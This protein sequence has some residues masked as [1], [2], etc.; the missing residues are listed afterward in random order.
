MPETT[1]S[2]FA[3]EMSDKTKATALETTKV[4]EQTYSSATK[5]AADFNRQWIEMVR[6]NTNST[7]D[8]VHQLFGVKSPT[9]FFE[10]WSAHAR[11]QFEAFTEQSKHLTTLAQKVT[12][13]TVEPLQAGMKGAA[14]K[15]A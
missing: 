12:T 15:A 7:L 5:G 14:A 4:L 10:L 11:K 9:D 8:F 13:D 6:A 2:T 1:P 3:K